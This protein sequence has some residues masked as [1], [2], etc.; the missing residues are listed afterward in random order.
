MVTVTG[1]GVDLRDM[2]V[3]RKVSFS[4]LDFVNLFC[5]LPLEKVLFSSIFAQKHAEIEAHTPR[6]SIRYTVYLV[7]LNPW[8]ACFL[9]GGGGGNFFGAYPP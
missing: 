9:A 1:W 6:K 2:L 8:D 5:L 7:N 4:Y 3:P